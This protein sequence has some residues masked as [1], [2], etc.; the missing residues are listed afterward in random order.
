MDYVLFNP[1]GISS[2]PW[3]KEYRAGLRAEELEGEAFVIGF[4]M[5]N[6]IMTNW[7]HVVIFKFFSCCIYPQ[8]YR[9]D[10]ECLIDFDLGFDYGRKLKVKNINKNKFF[11]IQ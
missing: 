10:E 8:K 7:I 5:G 2:R 4:C 11:P 1:V 6:D 3:F 9:F